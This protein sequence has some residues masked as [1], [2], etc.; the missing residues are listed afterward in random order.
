MG[1][2]KYV[3]IE[4]GSMKSIVNGWLRFTPIAELNDPAELLPVFNEGAI[5]ASLAELRQIGH[6]D[7][8]LRWLHC[9]EA[10]LDRLAPGTRILCAPQTKAEADRIIH[11]SYYS[12]LAFLREKHAVAVH[13]ITDRVGILSLTGRYDSLPMW[14][15]YANNARGAV[16]EYEGLD[17]VFLGD[18]TGSLNAVKPVRYS[19]NPIGMTFDPSTQDDLF[20]SKFDDWSYECEVRVVKALGECNS[21]QATGLFLHKIPN[22]HINRIILGWKC[23]ERDEIA[24]REI[25]ERENPSVQVVRASISNGRVTFTSDGKQ[26]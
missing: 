20:F 26:Q 7:E 2:F 16:I 13:M 24:V 6:T 11:S 12:D 18:E 15:H 4:A 25:V 5:L 19:A 23:P 10:V 3:R 22:A 9:Q 21:T 1:L 8:Q 17:T 14:A